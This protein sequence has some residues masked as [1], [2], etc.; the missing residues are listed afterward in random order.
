MKKQTK[1]L[2]PNKKTISNLT[3]AEM[4]NFVGGDATKGVKCNTKHHCTARCDSCGCGGGSHTC[5]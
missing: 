1:R 5:C 4:K 2:S 3:A